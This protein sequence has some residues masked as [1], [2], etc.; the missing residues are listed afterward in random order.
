MV[1]G[2]PLE[3]SNPEKQSEHIKTLQIKTPRKT[4][5]YLGIVGHVVITRV[6][7]GAARD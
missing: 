5:S 3:H 6:I 7:W 1:F 4:S 2:M